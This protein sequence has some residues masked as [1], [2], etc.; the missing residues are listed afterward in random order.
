MNTATEEW[1]IEGYLELMEYKKVFTAYN[2]YEPEATARK[3][4][5][6]VK[7]TLT[8]AKLYKRMVAVSEWEEA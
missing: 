6:A 3:F 7:G 8:N 2:T 1:R 5:D 4:F